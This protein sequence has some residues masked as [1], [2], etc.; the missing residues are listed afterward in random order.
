VC[1]RVNLYSVIRV[2]EISKLVTLLE[3]L[4]CVILSF[5]VVL[6]NALLHRLINF[7]SG[8]ENFISRIK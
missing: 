2:I 1:V 7:G 5:A 6:Y 4:T 8:A 3:L